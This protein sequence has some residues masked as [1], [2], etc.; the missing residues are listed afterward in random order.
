MIT[1]NPGR[2]VSGTCGFLFNSPKRIKC[3][4]HTIFQTEKE[5]QSLSKVRQLVNVRDRT[6]PHSDSTRVGWD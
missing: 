5:D 4:R 2:K 1:I 6:E 3:E